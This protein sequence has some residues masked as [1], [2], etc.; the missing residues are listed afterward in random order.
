MKAHHEMKKQNMNLIHHDLN[1]RKY[2]K[3]NNHNK[4]DLTTW[5]ASII[6]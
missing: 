6:V 2:K 4:A 5:W 1:Q 3:Q